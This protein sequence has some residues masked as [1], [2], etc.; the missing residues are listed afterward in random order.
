MDGGRCTSAEADYKIISGD[1][2]Y[3]DPMNSSVKNESDFVPFKI[4]TDIVLNGRAYVP[5]GKPTQSL[6][7]SI[8]VG[9]QRKNILVIG[10]R[11]CRFREKAVPAFTDP[12]PFTTMDIRYED[13]YGGIDIYSDTKLPCPYVRNPLGHGYVVKNTRKTIE[14]LA[15]PNIEDPNHR[16]TPQSLCIDHF[17]YWERQ[18]MPQG[19]GWYGKSWQPRAALA[20]VMPADRATE[21]EMRKAY[22]AVIPPEQRALYAQTQLPDM[23]FRFFNGASPGLALPFL[24]GDETIRTVN[25]SP[26]GEFLIKLPGE[27]P[28]IGIDIGNGI[29][30]PGVKLQTVMIRM[31]DQQVD[32]VWRAAAPYPGPDWLPEMKK[33]EVAVQ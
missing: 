8:Q 20:G 26:E 29:Q 21:Q 4:A 22:A 17:M 32:L 28:Q 15:L 5:N 25:L 13:A 23:D 2:F 18:P 6:I 16:L 10:D 30:E 7:A 11:V 27:K 31:E 33:L 9:S 12:K 1:L 19:F 14:N 3:G 24:S